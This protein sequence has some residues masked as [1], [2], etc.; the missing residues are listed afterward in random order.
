MQDN[1]TIR[2]LEHSMRNKN[3]KP[4]KTVKPDEIQKAG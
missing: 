1:L 2:S 3:I 4:S